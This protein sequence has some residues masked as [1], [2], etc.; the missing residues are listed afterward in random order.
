MFAAFLQD[1][2]CN[3][4]LEYDEDTGDLVAVYCPKCGKPIYYTDWCDDLEATQNWTVC[5]ICKVEYD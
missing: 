5:P 1:D 4:A 3:A 2:Y